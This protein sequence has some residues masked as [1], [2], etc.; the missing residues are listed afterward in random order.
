MNVNYYNLRCLLYIVN[1]IY[2][3]ENESDRKTDLTKR[4]ERRRETLAKFTAAEKKVAMQNETTMLE[5]V[6]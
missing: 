2:V 6:R 4:L 1:I 5:M 3:G